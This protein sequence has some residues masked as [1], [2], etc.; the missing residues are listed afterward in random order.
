MKKCFTIN[1]MRKKEE[2]NSYKILFEKNL[3]QAIEIFYPYNQSHQQIKD[4][5]ECVYE[6]MHLYPNVEIVLHLPHGIYNGLCLD[7]HL[8]SG[9]LEIMFGG[10]K[11]AS[12]FGVKKLTLH[13]GHIDITKDRGEYINK[14]VPLLKEFCDYVNQF[15]QV[16]MIENMPTYH[17][18]GYSPNEILEIIEKVNKHNL[19]F[20]F[21]TGHAHVSEY[22]DSSYLLVLKNYLMHI[23]YNDNDSTKDAHQRVGSG[24]IDFNKH[25]KVLDEIE[26]CE[27]HCIEVIY[28]TVDD[29]IQ[30]EKDLNKIKRYYEESI[31]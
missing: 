29:L 5:T 7:E 21:D 13:L 27:L 14:I 31:N 23:H 25:F 17:E 11:F 3:Y 26:Y 22:E 1:P 10:A 24:T 28:Q 30:Y 20:I 15:N 2:F 9:S 6:I 12:Q 16:I 8:D 4:Y 19:K 18:L